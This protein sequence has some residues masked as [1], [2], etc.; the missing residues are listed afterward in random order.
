MRAQPPIFALVFLAVG[1]WG[2]LPG[3]P[4]GGRV[5]LPPTPKAGA[6]I[7]LTG[8]WV[9][10]VP[11]GSRFRMFTPPKGDLAGIPLNA[12][13]TKLANAWDPATDEASG[14]HCK[15]Y[16]AASIMGIQG[17]FHITW[18]N[19]ATLKIE[20][21]AGTQTRLLHFNAAPPQTEEP[22]LQGYSVAAWDPTLKHAKQGGS[23]K[24]TTANLRPG[25]LRKNG[26]PYSGKTV[27][28]EYYD[29]VHE[30]DGVVLV[31]NTIVEDPMYLTDRFRTSTNLKKQRDASGW[32]PSACSPR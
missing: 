8:Y 26:V 9:S 3:P 30:P 2:Q 4:S 32:N 22:S 7:D 14:E 12:D 23:L 28:T 31:V 17:R 18:D 19:E 21:E 5:G 27:V 6:L 1:A 10:I 29:L 11:A 16:G 15:A 25:Y 20:T 13:G 24:V